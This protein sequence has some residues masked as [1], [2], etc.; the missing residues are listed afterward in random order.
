MYVTQKRSK[1]TTDKKKETSE[2]VIAQKKAVSTINSL[3][4]S[5]SAEFQ[6]KANNKEEQTADIK[7]SLIQRKN[8]RTGLP[9]QLKEGIE[10]LSGYSMDDVNVHYNSSKPE[11]L[12]AL[13]YTQG[14]DIFV[15]PGQNKHLGH[16]AWHVVQQMQGRVSPTSQMKG[17]NINDDSALEHEADIMG[18]KA[19]QF[20]I[21]NQNTIIQSE[22]KQSSVIQKLPDPDVE[23][24]IVDYDREADFNVDIK[25]SKDDKLQETFKNN[26]KHFCKYLYTFLFQEIKDIIKYTKEDKSI[27]ILSKK[28]QEIWKSIQICF[29]TTKNIN[30]I[31]GKTFS[32]TTGADYMTAIETLMYCIKGDILTSLRNNAIELLSS[33]GEIDRD[34]LE[35]IPDEYD[36][37]KSLDDYWDYNKI[38][39]FIE[40]KICNNNIVN[41]NLFNDLKVTIGETL[42]DIFY[43]SCKQINK[44]FFSKNKIG[45]KVT[46]IDLTDSDVHTRGIGVCIVT[47]EDGQKLVV[48][49]ERKDF[50]KIVYGK[51]ESQNDQESLASIFNK[52]GHDV[53]ELSIGVSEKH[54]SAIEYFEHK[55]MKKNMKDSEKALIDKKS[56]ED[57]IEFASLLGLGDLHHENMVYG[58]KNK[59]AQLID[60][61]VGLK[62]P[63]IFDP[64]NTGK[65]NP[66]A[67][68]IWYGEMAFGE[69]I[70]PAKDF[71]DPQYTNERT[72]EKIEELKKFLEEVKARFSGLKGRRVVIPTGDLYRIR[73]KIYKGEKYT[74]EDYITKLKSSFTYKEGGWIIGNEIEDAYNLMI[75]DFR[76]GRIPFYEHDFDTG[77]IIQKFSGNEEKIVLQNQ[78]YVKAQLQ[79]LNND[80]VKLQL[81]PQDKKLST[82]I[83]QNI[84]VLEQ[85]LAN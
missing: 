48:K 40:E 29:L 65:L 61:E 18:D 22:K 37:M 28:S 75:A 82:I 66:L 10:G 39:D 25:T 45:K 84:T 44:S 60:A 71:S 9:E 69:S 57:V 7:P 73:T 33:A 2:S 46:K 27:N 72:P 34:L 77:N 52:S 20:K 8:N 12:H 42:N 55:D 53:G 85:W 80:Q 56:L 68:S 43:W 24:V 26:I 54:G 36:N 3:E 58:A 21:N 17:V 70:P 6:P 59:K 64:T 83:E 13:A 31:I 49:P 23:G 74:L 32:C 16:E 1:L 51:K 4:L 79:L 76:K 81:H 62:Y 78:V 41:E 19:I 11:R 67:T 5:K 63:L 50:E 35:E 38:I 14:R 15:A 47:F 30:T